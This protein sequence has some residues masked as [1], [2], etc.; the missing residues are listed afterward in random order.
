[1]LTANNHQPDERL[2]DIEL[3]EVPLVIDWNLLLIPTFSGNAEEARQDRGR[4]GRR[5]ALSPEGI[6]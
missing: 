4:G 3:I 2:P 6:S 5:R 1:M